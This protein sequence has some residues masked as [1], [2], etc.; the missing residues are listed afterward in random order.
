MSTLLRTKYK[1]SIQLISK[2]TRRLPNERPN[3]EQ[4]LNVKHFW[5]L[6]ENEFEFE[7]ESRNILNSRTENDNFS[8]YS[9]L[10]SKLSQYSREKNTK[11]RVKDKTLN[12]WRE[13]E[14]IIQDVTRNFTHNFM[15]SLIQDVI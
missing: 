12:F 1:E 3:C 13:M 4:I 8:V 2:M 14:I 10:Q 11:F 9:I 5:A 15:E 7:N 6:H